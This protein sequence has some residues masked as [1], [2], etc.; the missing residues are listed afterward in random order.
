MLRSSVPIFATPYQ[1]NMNKPVPHPWYY[2][3]KR[4]QEAKKTQNK[5][6]SVYF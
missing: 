5:E 1:V 6:V 2:V 4:A 3:M